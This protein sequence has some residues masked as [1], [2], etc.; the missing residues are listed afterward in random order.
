MRFNDRWM[1]LFAFSALASFTLLNFSAA[2]WQ[3]FD[4]KLTYKIPVLNTI[5]KQSWGFFGPYPVLGNFRIDYKCIFSDRVQE[6]QLFSSSLDN[7]SGPYSRIFIS[8]NSEYLMESLFWRSVWSVPQKYVKLCDSGNCSGLLSHIESRSS[9]L[10]LEKI[11]RGICISESKGA[12]VGY[13]TKFVLENVV[14]FTN[15]K[16]K[17]DIYVRDHLEM[18]ARSI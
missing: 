8:N 11:V 2:A 16:S 12:L 14:F 7:Y 15:R 3:V 17:E 4:G 18:P 13:Q 1:R 9:Y 10:K 6:W 5:F